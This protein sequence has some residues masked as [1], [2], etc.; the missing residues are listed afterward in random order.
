MDKLDVLPVGTPLTLKKE[1]MEDKEEDL[2][3]LQPSILFR[4]ASTYGDEDFRRRDD[5]CRDI[6]FRALDNKEISEKRRLFIQKE[7]TR[8]SY[9]ALDKEGDL[10]VSNLRSKLIAQKDVERKD[11]E[12][13]DNLR[14]RAIYIAT[15]G[16]LWPDLICKLIAEYAGRVI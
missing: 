14:Y 6:A 10:V 7:M 1:E 16:N 12:V 8:I 4:S 5:A 13:E 9:G 11:R 15:A 2:L 3:L